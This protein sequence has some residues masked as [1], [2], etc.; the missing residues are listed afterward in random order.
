MPYDTRCTRAKVTLR[1]QRRHWGVDNTAVTIQYRTTCTMHIPS[2][3][4]TSR[5]QPGVSQVATRNGP[6]V[7]I[8]WR[9]ACKLTHADARSSCLPIPPCAFAAKA[10]CSHASPRTPSASGLPAALGRAVATVRRHRRVDQVA[11]R[12]RRHI[13]R[14]DARERG[15]SGC[16]ASHCCCGMGR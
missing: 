7:F 4:T 11:W 6:S 14:G 16:A 10:P 9:A 8:G 12:S 15:A 1:G 5:P 13:H 3:T 2:S